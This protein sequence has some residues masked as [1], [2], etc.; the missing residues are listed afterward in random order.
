M[1]TDVIDTGRLLTRELRALQLHLV[2]LDRQTVTVAEFLGARP[3]A[4]GIDFPRLDRIL[5]NA[6][7]VQRQKPGALFEFEAGNNSLDQVVS[8]FAE[9]LA[10][11]EPYRRVEG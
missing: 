7:K 6:Q 3:T 1:S 10:S 9:V 2:N 11:A 8:D 5:A 4:H